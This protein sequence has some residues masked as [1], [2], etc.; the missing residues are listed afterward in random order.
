M[1]V[2]KV[3]R[4][5][6]L[7]K[8]R[9]LLRVEVAYPADGLSPFIRIMTTLAASDVHFFQDIRQNVAYYIYVAMGTV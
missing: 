3:R 6:T 5:I 7:I 1:E 4:L 2:E 8:W 9:A